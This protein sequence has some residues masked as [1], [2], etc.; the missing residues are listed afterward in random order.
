MNGPFLS[1]YGVT[2]AA[3]RDDDEGIRNLLRDLPADEAAAAAEGALL[4]MAELV[5]ERTTPEE[6]AVIIGAVQQLS[7]TDQE[8]TT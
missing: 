8:T 4:A 7:L 1:A 5:R 6:L 2:V 3:L